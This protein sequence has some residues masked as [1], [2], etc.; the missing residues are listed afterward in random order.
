MV[1]KTKYYL[2]TYDEEF[3]KLFFFR[4]RRREFPIGRR[5]NTGGNIE[6]G[7][8]ETVDAGAAGRCCGCRCCCRYVNHCGRHCRCVQTSSK[9]TGTARSQKKNEVS[10]YI[11]L[12]WWAWKCDAADC[13]RTKKKVFV[14]Y[15]SMMGLMGCWVVLYIPILVCVCV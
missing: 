6:P 9:A 8:T 2:P 12:V 10:K 14:G 15:V 5:S 4:I 13:V 11:L 7:Q 3:N 1:S